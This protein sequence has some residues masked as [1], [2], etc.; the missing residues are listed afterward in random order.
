MHKWL[1]IEISSF[2]YM[3]AGSI[4]LTTNNV[5]PILLLADKYSVS[6]LEQVCV[7]YMMHHIVESPDTNRTLS[8]YQYA[9]MTR[10]VLL[11][12][13]CKKFILSNFNIILKTVDWMELPQ[14]EVVEFV[15]SSDLVIGNEFDLWLH[16]EK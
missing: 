16:V 15:S 7:T 8:W 1:P 10:N 13:R 9:K 5:L 3:Y 2:R 12:D 6:T 14:A 11:V 4:G